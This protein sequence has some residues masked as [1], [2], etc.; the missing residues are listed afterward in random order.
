[1][2]AAPASGTRSVSFDLARFEQ[3]A[4]LGD[5]A[6]LPA[7]R[8]ILDLFEM[9]ADLVTSDD[10]DPESKA[11][12]QQ[13]RRLANA[14]ASLLAHPNLELSLQDCDWLAYH[15]RHLAA[16]FRM[17]WTDGP[18]RVFRHVRE[19]HWNTGNRARFRNVLAAYSI[20]VSEEFDW[21]V[22]LE[23]EPE[24]T[25]AFFLAN[26]THR[27][28]LDVDAARRRDRL[29]E[30]V[31]QI[32]RGKLREDTL[33]VL[34]T[35][36]MLC[37]YAM[38]PDR[39]AIKYHLNGLIQDLLAR[40]A[41]FSAALPTKREKADRPTIVVV[42]EVL[43][44]G[45]AMYKTYANFLRQL[46]TKFN[47]VLVTKETRVDETAKALFDE[48][49]V[50]EPTA[51]TVGISNRIKSL[52][53]AAV[54]YPSVGM[55]EM[56]V[57]LCNLRLAPIQI[58][59]VGHPATTHS[60]SIDY[61]VMGHEYYGGAECFSEQVTL[62]RSGGALFVPEPLASPV[63]PQ[64]R[65]DPDILRVAIPSSP[66]KLNGSFLDVC[67]RVVDRSDRTVEYWFF[68]N[69]AGLRY[70]DCRMQIEHRLP[71]AVVYPKLDFDAYR[72]CISRCD[73]YFGSYPFGGANI[74][75][76]AMLQGLPPIVFEGPEPHSR[77]DKRFVHLF[78]LPEWL[79]ARS[80]QQYEKAAMRLIQNDEERCTIARQILDANP[81]EMLFS[82]EQ[83]AYPT[84]FVDTVWWLY[85]NHE[86]VKASDR[87]VWT[88]ED[89]LAVS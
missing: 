42:A 74:G 39:H 80:E 41:V 60:P 30:L 85:E 75:V 67:R 9:G 27:A 21:Q 38:A 1:V 40:N 36:W 79:I 15:N 13:Y 46:G 12:T 17:A 51:G 23:R 76:D 7:F 14:V 72:D 54:Y 63:T 71:G 5:A 52:S 49:F 69:V 64:V 11:A 65:D 26:F 68:P 81:E 88:W 33:P 66:M 48:T 57:L 28:L 77:T 31:P 89:R 4:R 55:S 83:S 22:A 25:L 45:H 87:R 62:L 32:V 78:G 50:F 84:D 34:T 70:R 56:A 37:S 3:F 35:A 43:L 61:M 19:A 82:K 20:A 18:D 47:L 53:P 16:V 24:A 8:Q 58:A 44:V 10:R 29:F 73:V 6:A 2:S 86:R 59:S